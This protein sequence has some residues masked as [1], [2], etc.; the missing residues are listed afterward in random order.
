MSV[1]GSTLTIKHMKENLKCPVERKPLADI[2]D[3]IDKSFSKAEE[4]LIKNEWCHNEI[5]ARIQL[6]VELID[7]FGTWHKKADCIQP[8]LDENGGWYPKIYLQAYLGTNKPL[9]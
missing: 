3:T 4:E 2:L 1:A 6:F 9:S 7:M 8:I 5:S